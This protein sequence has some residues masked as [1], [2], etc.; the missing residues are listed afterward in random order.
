MFILST[1]MKVNPSWP[2]LSNKAR[3]HY[4]LYKN[5]IEGGLSLLYFDGDPVRGSSSWRWSDSMEN[6][7][8]PEHCA[9]ADRQTDLPVPSGLFLQQVQA[10][11]PPHCA[12]PQRVE[13][14]ETSVLSQEVLSQWKVCLCLL[15]FF[16]FRYLLC[17]FIWLFVWKSKD[18]WG[19]RN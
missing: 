15:F 9:Q 3:P 7:E 16:S 18:G 19:I 1:E 2:E 8:I 13:C 6:P 5:K 4:V 11:V 10:A 17:L 12:Q 14:G